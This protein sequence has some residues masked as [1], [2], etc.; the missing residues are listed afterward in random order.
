M[1]ALA[2]W[3]MLFSAQLAVPILV[4]AIGEAC[5]AMPAALRLTYWRAVLCGGL[6]LAAPSAM[7]VSLSTVTVDARSVVSALTSLETVNPSWRLSDVILT[8]WL[9]GVVASAAW[10]AVGLL[11][12]RRLR[13]APDVSPV[14]TTLQGPDAPDLK[15]VAIWWHPRITHPVSFGIRR[16]LILLPLHA[17][18]L[19]REALKAVIDHEALHVA[20]GEPPL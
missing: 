11:A 7:G 14:G 6:L 12:L 9:G 16:P 15:Q 5:I 17:R 10:F 2:D 8:V 1:A 13:N 19:P 4:A 20:H 18:T 3:L